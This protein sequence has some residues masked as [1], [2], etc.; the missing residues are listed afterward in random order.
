MAAQESSSSQ[1]PLSSA[2]VLQDKPLVSLRLASKERN[3]ELVPSFF[4]RR[5]H[6]LYS[7]R[8]FSDPLSYSTQTL[9]P[10]PPLELQLLNPRSP[11]PSLSQQTNTSR[12]TSQLLPPQ[13]SLPQP[14][15]ELYE[16]LPPS[17]TLSTST[18]ALRLPP[19]SNPPKASP[20]K[21]GG[22]EASQQLPPPPS[23][24]RAGL[25]LDTLHCRLRVR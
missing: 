21:Q 5:V 16:V 1:V 14:P 13:P 24:R 18:S 10:S 6:S 11:S 3:V 19:P 20:P 8:S 17:P 23:P 2:Q 4:L 12:S 9:N 15:S 22:N 7:S 25:S